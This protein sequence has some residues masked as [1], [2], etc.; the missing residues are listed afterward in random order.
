MPYLRTA[1]LGLL[2]GGGGEGDS[3]GEGVSRVIEVLDAY[4]LSKDDFTETLRE[5]QFTAEGDKLLRGT[6]AFR[7]S[8]WPLTVHG[9]R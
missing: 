1:L 4:G 5:M 7:S 2:R 3:G 8:G 6:H 9:T